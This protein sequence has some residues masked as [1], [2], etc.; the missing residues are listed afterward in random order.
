MLARKRT[1][2]Q[3]GKNKKFKKVTA[4]KIETDESEYEEEERSEIDEEGVDAELQRFL[5][6]QDENINFC[7]VCEGESL[8]E[9]H[10]GEE[11][12]SGEG[13]V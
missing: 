9:G 8:R 1:S 6:E 2:S 5:D 3:P 13:R 4:N 10:E 7:N 12:N 11:G